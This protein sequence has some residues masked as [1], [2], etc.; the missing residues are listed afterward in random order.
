MTAR[1]AVIIS[2]TL[3]FALMADSAWASSFTKVS[4]HTSGDELEINFAEHGLEPGQNYGYTGSAG[5]VTETLQCYRTRT[6]TPTPRTIQVSTQNTSPDVRS[7]RAN[8]DGVVRGFIFVYPILP[9]FRGCGA[10]LETVPIFI[11]F[12]DYQLVNIVT[13][14]Y[15]DVSGTVSGPI[16]P[17]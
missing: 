14:D 4:A 7:Y 12:T 1:I 3:A 6:F 16:E 9:S 17:D 5:S 2:L 10:R 15:V 13:F 11:S 8:D